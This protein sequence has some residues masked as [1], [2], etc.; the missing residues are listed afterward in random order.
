MFLVNHPARPVTSSDHGQQT[1]EDW[2]GE[3]VAFA[4]WLVFRIF[5]VVVDA[6]LN[7]DSIYSVLLVD[8]ALLDH[9]V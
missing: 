8:Y 5:V 6:A 9:V 4:L 7:E 2:L 3:N 1:V